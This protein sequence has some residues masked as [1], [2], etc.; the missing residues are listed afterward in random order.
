M[1][2][3]GHRA[4]SESSA[5]L[6]LAGLS[7]WARTVTSPIKSRVNRT[8][9]RAQWRGTSTGSQADLQPTDGKKIN[10]PVTC[11]TYVWC[12]TPPGLLG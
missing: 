11:G 5:G 7:P 6:R 4:A 2:K 10:G 12:V 1:L 8:A 3:V 9:S